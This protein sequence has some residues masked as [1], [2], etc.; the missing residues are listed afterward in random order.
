MTYYLIYLDLPISLLLNFP[1]LRNM[2]SEMSVIMDS[3]KFLIAT[4]P[5]CNIEIDA[6]ETKIRKK[7]TV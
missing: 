1:K 3:I 2:T 5:N 7:E 6:T 4:D